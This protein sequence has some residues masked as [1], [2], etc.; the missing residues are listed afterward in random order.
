VDEIKK[1]LLALSTSRQSQRTIEYAFNCVQKESA[2]LIALFV[3]DPDLPELIFSKLTDIGFL[4]EKPGEEV[5]KALLKEYRLRGEEKLK[6]IKNLANKKG[7]ECATILKI[8]NFAE[9]CLKLIN[10]QNPF[11]IVLTR[12][13][14]SNISRFLFGS[15]VNEIKK[16]SSVPVKIIKEN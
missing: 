7:I 8:G 1:I 2:S 15:A 5:M 10:E 9:E 6:E 13:K 16:K 3:V 11:L 4:G 14:R 12:A